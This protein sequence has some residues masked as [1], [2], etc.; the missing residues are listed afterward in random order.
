MNFHADEEVLYQLLISFGIGTAI[1]LERE[2]RNKAA[3]LRTMIMICLGSTIFT[4]ISIGLGGTGNPDRIAAAIVSGIGFLGAGVIFKDGLSVVGITTAT[5]IWIS[6]ALGMAVGA[7]EYFTALVGGIVV[8]IVLILFE[9]LQNL[10]ERYQQTRSY[11]ISF[12]ES[13]DFLFKELMAEKLKVLHLRF[14][15]K[16]DIKTENGYTLIYEISGNETHL[17]EFNSFLKREPAVK[18]FEY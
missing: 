9:K 12:K 17:S 16:R 18:S 7:S 8:L 2:Y 5:T 6:A 15:L 13:E 1:G 3:G 4:Q 11:R 14:R 10:F